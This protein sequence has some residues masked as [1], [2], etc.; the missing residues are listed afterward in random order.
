MRVWHDWRAYRIKFAK[1]DADVPPELL[2]MSS[3]ELCTWISRF[4]HEVRKQDKSPYPGETLYQIICGIQR[5]LRGNGFAEVDF[6]SSG[7]FRA[8]KN[9]LDGRMKELRREGVG[10][11]KNHTEAITEEEEMILWE[12][13]LL[14]EH[15]PV[16]LRDTMVWFCGMFFALRGGKELRELKV[17]QITIHETTDGRKY[18]EY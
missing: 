1:S 14:G 7:K 13:G 8:L 12:K 11:D 17:S 4:I 15:S 18:L 16:V 6:F 5:Y 2:E 3:D 10:V 9:V